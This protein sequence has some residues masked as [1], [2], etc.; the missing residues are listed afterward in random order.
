MAPAPDSRDRAERRPLSDSLRLL[1]V[2]RQEPSWTGLAL[3]LDRLGCTAPRFQWCSAQARAAAL[4]RDETFDVIVVGEPADGDSD[5]L[6]FIQALRESGTDEPI[7]VVSPRADD[8]WLLRCGELDLEALSASS[9]WESRSLATWIRRAIERSEA[10]RDLQRLRLA[11][12]RQHSENREGTELIAEQW[13]QVFTTSEDAPSTTAIRPELTTAYRDLLRTYAF[14][15]TGRLQD[16]LDS[17]AVRIQAANLPAADLLRLHCSCL[18]AL[19]SG[20]GNRS[21]RHLQQNADL[22]AVEILTRVADGYRQRS[23]LRGLGD[24]GID[25]L[26]A[27][28]LRQK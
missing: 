3:Q 27:E 5:P 18:K 20:C 13:R 21:V 7:L 12:R 4:L 14:F 24:H 22:F 23:A 16:E 26:Q 17:L 9:G 25:L 1:C 10:A 15:G 19:L 11:E 8:A 2:C 6:V 28:T